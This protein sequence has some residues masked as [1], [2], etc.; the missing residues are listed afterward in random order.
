MVHFLVIDDS[1]LCIRGIHLQ[2][3][4]AA[5]H[6][7]LTTLILQ[8]PLCLDALRVS[9]LDQALQQGLKNIT[10]GDCAEEYI[11]KLGELHENTEL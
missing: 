9:P 2:W 4:L 10:R 6:C 8:I 7:Y 3:R 11:I 5:D 1:P